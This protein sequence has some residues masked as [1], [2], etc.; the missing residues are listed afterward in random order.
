MVR[1]KPIKCPSEVMVLSITHRNKLLMSDFRAE[2][3]A[4]WRGASMHCSWWQLLQGARG[5]AACAES[6]PALGELGPW[7]AEREMV[8]VAGWGEGVVCPR[9]AT[10]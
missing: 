8:V 2:A 5:S 9:G 1:A 7:S 6:H 4:G 3:Q 10:R